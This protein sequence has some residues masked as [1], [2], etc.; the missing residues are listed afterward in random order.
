MPASKGSTS[1]ATFTFLR[2]VPQ[3]ETTDFTDREWS[4]ADDMICRS[5][6]MVGCLSKC[7]HL[8]VLRNPSLTLPRDQ[9]YGR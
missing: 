3:I 1:I 5:E 9:I 8:A 7:H 4:E 2:I 6:Q